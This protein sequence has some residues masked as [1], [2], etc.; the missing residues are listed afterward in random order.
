[1]LRSFQ[2]LFIPLWVG[3]FACP[4]WA[5]EGIEFFEKKIRPVL[6]TH[7]Y[8]CHSAATDEPKGGLRLDWR[9]GILQGG[10]SGPAVVPGQGNKSL[11]VEALRHESLEMPPERKLPN[12]VIAD[13]VRWIDQGAADPR[14][15]LP[16]A[17]V[18]AKAA[19]EARYAERRQWW[20]FQP[21]ARPQ[22]PQVQNTM[23]SADPIDRFILAKL[24]AQWLTPSPP[25]SKTALIRRLSF[26]ITGLP[27][28]APQ[29]EQYL[30]DSSPDAWQQAVQRMLN[31]PHF[32][33]HWARHWMDVVRYTDTYGYE[34]DIPAKGAWRYRDYLIRAINADVPWNQMIREQIA[35]DLLEEP[36]RNDAEQ[37]N[38]SLAGVMFYQMG[39]KR[40][41][42]SAQFNGIHQEMLDNK[43]DAFSKAFQALTI[44]CAR[45]HD[46]KLGPISQQEYYALAGVFMSSRWVT[47]TL[48]LPER[49]AEQIQTLQQIKAQLRTSLAA[50]WLQ[51]INQLP[52]QLIEATAGKEG[53]ASSARVDVMSLS[54]LNLGNATKPL[55]KNVLGPWSH[56]VGM[57]RA[58]A[59][60]AGQDLSA[61]WQT[62]GSAYRAEQAKRREANAREFVVAADFS[63]GVPPGW[64]VDGV[65][66]REVVR[67]GDFTVTPQGLQAVG[68]LLPGG[69]YTHSISKR[70]NGA[71][72]TPY[73]NQFTQ[74][75]MS[76][77]CVGGDFSTHRTVVDNAFLTERQVY[78]KQS[79][80]AWVRL[81]MDPGLRDRHVYFEFA[82]KTSNPNFPPRVGL[83][84][85]CSEQQS[86]SPASWFGITRVLLH[87]TTTTPKDELSR[88]QSLF[89]G[90]TPSNANELAERYAAWF[91]DSVQ[92]WANDTADADHVQ[93]LNWLLRHTLLTN[94]LGEP[95]H[96]DRILAL[97]A[98]YRRR[99]NSNCRSPKPSTAWRDFD[100]GLQLPSQRPRRLRRTR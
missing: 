94:Q 26:A 63:K 34:W 56:A 81:A 59:E 95:H 1:M 39:E 33:E 84:G 82:T 71:I 44:S 27:P 99:S 67:C 64:S 54:L 19:W 38:E 96:D 100:P 29:L 28:T 17:D 32:G 21:L 6:V 41:G 40:H 7:C 65:G 58:V 87:D 50:L 75:Q 15:E 76:F 74:A 48:D 91:R 10:E 43:I 12:A 57:Q 47:N 25:A 14:T 55:W 45:C 46:H 3:L 60:P 83:G 24:E 79:E 89:T 77:E 62:L 68:R 37:T 8:E 73:L 53:S 31:S 9:P 98:D 69:M 42:D 88:F 66:L 5:D 16:K 92:A 13:F 93:L 97:V 30:G 72:R 70:L 18:V 51:E 90:Q 23:W 4:T 78:L 85:A 80:P 86:A 36:R 49:H 61:R 11:L 20:S 35:G 22:L 52:E 2:L